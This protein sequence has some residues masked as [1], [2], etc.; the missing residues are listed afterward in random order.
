MQTCQVALV[1]ALLCCWTADAA[2]GGASDCGG[3]GETK[4]LIVDSKTRCFQMYTPSGAKQPM[5]VVV[6]F[7]GKGGRASASCR[8]ESEMVKYADSLGYALICGDAYEDW[9]FPKIGDDLGVTSAN[10]RPCAASDS[11][12]ATYVTKLFEAIEANTASYDVNKIY[13]MGFSQGSMMTNWASTCFAA[14]IRGVVQAGS[15]IKLHGAAVTAEICAASTNAKCKAGDDDGVGIPGGAGKCDACE[16]FPI[17]P[18]QNQNNVVGEPLKYCLYLGCDDYLAHSVNHLAIY[19]ESIGAPFN[20]QFYEAAHEA[21]IDW[22]PM[23]ADCHGIWSGTPKN[24]N[25]VTCSSSSFFVTGQME[26]GGGVGG[27]AG[28]GAG[29]GG[30][31]PTCT[32]ERTTLCC[33]D[34]TCGGP[35]TAEN[36]P[37]DCSGSSNSE[38]SGTGGGGGGEPPTC[39]TERTTL[40]CGDKTC[41][42][43]ET[44]ENCPADCSRSTTAQGEISGLSESSTSKTPDSMTSG[45][46]C[47]IMSSLSVVSAVTLS[48]SLHR[49]WP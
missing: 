30:E 20:L 11:P 37:A 42:G 26:G 41:G 13:F 5:P 14:K 8:A 49:H 7:H 46:S 22:M 32:T 4:E 24:D 25:G 40:C 28:G 18:A 2:D 44:V 27:G 31:P 45:T 38:A 35:E 34:K 48:C 3:A 17:Q 23:V 39:T 9:Q 19:L 33:G 43:P 1:L 6:F 15:G 47:A 12:D 36:C 10:P 16:Y 21:P 29:A